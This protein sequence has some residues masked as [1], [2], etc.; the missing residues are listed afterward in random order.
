MLK[1]QLYHLLALPLLIN[2]QLD[3]SLKARLVSSGSEDN[4][5]DS[6]VEHGICSSGGGSL[7]CPNAAKLDQRSVVRFSITTQGFATSIVTMIMPA[8]VTMT[9]IIRS[10]DS[11]LSLLTMSPIASNP[12]PATST[13]VELTTITET[14][15]SPQSTEPPSST[16]LPTTGGETGTAT[17]VAPSEITSQSG[18]GLVGFYWKCV[19]LGMLFVAGVLF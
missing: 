6:K 15:Q 18:A 2:A 5:S 14:P 7:Y 1:S 10:S 8:I 9:N 16:T 13:I 4:S 19:G 12:A 17:R 11:Q 3:Q